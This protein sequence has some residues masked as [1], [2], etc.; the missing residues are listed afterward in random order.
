MKLRNTCNLINKYKVLKYLR[1]DISI[2]DWFLI[3]WWT[4]CETYLTFEE[5]FILRRILIWR[6]IRNDLRRFS[7]TQK[8]NLVYFIQF[9]FIK[10]FQAA[11]QFTFWVPSLSNDDEILCCDN[12][13]KNYMFGVIFFSV[14]SCMWIAY[15]IC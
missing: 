10:S 3:C 13:F 15:I 1:H 4:W 11:V 9:G 2:F 5:C 8:N 14:M 12:I 7:R 6:R